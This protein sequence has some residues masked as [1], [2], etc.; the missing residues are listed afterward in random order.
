MPRAGAVT[1]SGTPTEDQVLTAA[2]TLADEDGLGAISYQWQ[3][4]GS[5]ISGATAGTYT[6][7][8]ADVGTTITVVA[9]YTD[10]EGTGESVTSAGVGPVANVN[11]APSGSVTI[12]GTPTEDQVL[13][14]ANTLADEDGL[15]A[16]SYQWQRNGSDI[17][18]AT[19]GTYTLTQADVGTTITVVASY[20]DDEGAGESVTSAGVGP[21]A[22]LND[23]PLA[24]NDAAT[25]NED[26][27]LVVSAANLLANDADVDLDTLYIDSFTQP[28]NGSVSDNGD[29]TF[30]YTSTANFNG[31]D[32]FT[33]TVA[34]GNGGSDTATVDIT[35]TPVNDAPTTGDDSVSTSE[36]TPL[37]IT[38]ASLL[39]ND[40]DV[41][42][43]TLTITGFTQPANGVVVDNGDGTF[44]YTP[45]VNFKGTDSFAYTVTDG[46]GAT[47]IATADITVTSM[48]DAPVAT[49]DSFATDEDTPLVI[50]AASLLANDTDVDF[51]TL[52]IESFT[53][54]AHGNVVDNGD[55]TFTYTPNADF[56]GADS[57]IYT[58][59]DGNGATSTTAVTVDVAAKPDGGPPP[60]DEPQDDSAG[61]DPPPADESPGDDSPNSNARGEEDFASDESLASPVPSGVQRWNRGRG[62]SAEIAVEMAEQAIAEREVSGVG[63][64]DHSASTS[65]HAMTSAKEPTLLNPLVR[66][67]TKGTSHST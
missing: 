19:A 55:D 53:Q 63:D 29:G 34:D 2:N 37:V 27:P 25:T 46:N 22:N 39:T 62:S 24:N 30:T 35:V 4:N 9:S 1:I 57:F 5:D 54:P 31:A 52:S 21:I 13:T 14:A 61:D 64:L 3:R 44:T 33:Y 65:T 58:V 15:G 16:I 45:G 66:P 23:D 11:D 60:L 32:S 26:S 28:A 67:S 8:Q 51:D 12:S 18:G 40:T 38:A 6:L 56:N 7:T 59:S 41:D 42:G 47:D 50:D 10:D 20:T 17:S 48:N 49:E 36:D 43:D